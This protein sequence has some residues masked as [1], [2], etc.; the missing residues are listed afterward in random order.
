MDKLKLLI[1]TLLVGEPLD[2]IHRDHRLVGNFAARRE[3]HIESDWLLIYRI[4]EKRIYFERTG[5]HADLFK[6]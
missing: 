3:C 1:R 4:A 2:S 6:K 5:T